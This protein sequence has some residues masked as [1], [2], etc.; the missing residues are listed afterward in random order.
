MTRIGI[1]VRTAFCAV[2]A[3]ALGTALAPAARADATADFY[4]SHPVQVII[5]Y[6]AGGGYDLYARVLARHMGRHLPG[7]GSLVPQNMPGAGSVK[8][9]NYIYSVAP[10]DGSVFGTFGRG[11][12]VD[13]LIGNGEAHFDARKFTWIGSVTAETSVCVTWNTSKVKTWE[14]ALKTDFTVGGEGAGSDP[15]IFAMVMKNVFGAKMKLVTG[16]PGGNEI[17][18]AMERGEVDGRCGWSW[19]SVLST[20]SS[21]LKDKKINVFIQ[22]AMKKNKEIDAPL[23]MD[24]AKNE[25][26]RQILTLFFS[27]QE[28]GRPFAAPPNLPADRKKALIDAFNATMKDKGFL[29]DSKKQKLEVDP[30]DAQ[31][32][33]KLVDD[34]YKTPK[35]TL[36]EGK[37]I[38][39]QGAR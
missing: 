3:V 21:W 4:K 20:K 36:E 25:H 10:K 32:L 27:R 26:Q 24:L 8:A 29:D 1:R 13:P 19:S 11:E 17:N 39:A 35:E 6:T 28:M 22:M 38:V 9:A 16:Y 37:R 7:G 18:L 14:D 15:D 31:E 34:I 5:G 30:V 2:G 33:T 12:A 23:I